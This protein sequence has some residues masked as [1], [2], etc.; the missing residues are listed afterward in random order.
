MSILVVGSTRQSQSA[1]S[2][3]AM[4][5]FL[6][7]CSVQSHLEST[8]GQHK[9]LL[10][11]YSNTALRCYPTCAG[12]HPDWHL[13]AQHPRG[14]FLTK[15]MQN[16]SQQ[17][18]PKESSFSIPSWTRSPEQLSNWSNLRLVLESR[19]TRKVGQREEKRTREVGTKM[20][21]STW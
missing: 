16:W 18:K 17:F 3:Q 21:C 6:Q 7:R 9:E 8:I 15:C 5:L 14:H 20:Q 11:T 19:E 10:W 4:K 13:T 1:C 2:T 12:E